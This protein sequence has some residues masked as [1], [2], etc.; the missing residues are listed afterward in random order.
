M[1]QGKRQFEPKMRQCVRRALKL[2]YLIE[3]EREMVEN[4]LIYNDL[5][6]RLESSDKDVS[7]N[8]LDLINEI[9]DP[10][11]TMGK[12]RIPKEFF[13]PLTE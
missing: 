5:K 3:F 13:C 1:V 12:E 8:Q 10:D 9:F 2:R 7:Q 11:Y 4:Q 6:R